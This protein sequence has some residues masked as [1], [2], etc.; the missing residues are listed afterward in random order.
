MREHENCIKMIFRVLIAILFQ[1]SF[2]FNFHGLSRRPNANLATKRMTF[3]EEQTNEGTKQINQQHDERNPILA[4][5]QL[6]HQNCDVVILPGRR[7]QIRCHHETNNHG[8]HISLF[9]PFV[10]AAKLFQ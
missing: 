4:A 6:N 9:Q 2:G 1:T 3:N 8:M 5:Y 7:R 10:N